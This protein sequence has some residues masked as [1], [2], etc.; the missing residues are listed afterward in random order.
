[1]LAL[2][3]LRSAGWTAHQYDR[4]TGVRG[5]FTT[6]FSGAGLTTYWLLMRLRYVATL[7]DECLLRS[8]PFHAFLF[9]TI[10]LVPRNHS[11]RTV[12]IR[13]GIPRVT[14]THTRQNPGVWA[15]LGCAVLSLEGEWSRCE[16][17][18]GC[19]DW[20]QGQRRNEMCFLG[21]AEAQ[22]PQNQ[23]CK[24]CA[25]SGEAMVSVRHWCSQYPMPDGPV[26][27]AGRLLTEVSSS[28]STL[29]SPSRADHASLL[30]NDRL[31]IVQRECDLAQQPRPRQIPSGNKRVA[32]H[33]HFL[34]AATRRGTSERGMQPVWRPRQS[35]TAGLAF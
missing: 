14:Q 7:S 20:L 35:A 6:V 17:S 34:M 4:V 27:W 31:G 8:P 16:E 24:C 18:P 32:M 25:R 23:A 13:R 28:P 29:P 22:N 15:G 3:V 26:G 9:Y 30:M 1:M 2:D 33:A 21:F 11:N 19:M 10:Y 12:T 5:L